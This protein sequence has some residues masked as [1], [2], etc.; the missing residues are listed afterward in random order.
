M[1]KDQ[2]GSCGLQFGLGCWLITNQPAAGTINVSAAPGGGAALLWH[3]N[4]TTGGN[5][6]KAACG[7]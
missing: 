5:L 7:N 2:C 1:S 6:R 4:V 3:K